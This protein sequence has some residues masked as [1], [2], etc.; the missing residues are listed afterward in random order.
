ML[1][2]KNIRKKYITGDLTQIA[3]DGISLTFRDNEFVAIL[4]PSGSGKTAL[5]NFEGGLDRYVSGDLVIK[6][7]STKK[8]TDRDWDTYRNHSI[9]FVFQ[10]YNLIGHQSILSNVALALT[11]SGISRSECRRRAKEALEKVGLGDQLHKRPNQ[12]SGGQMQRVAI[13]RA[14]VNNPDILLADEPTGA[15]DTETG[16]QVME[17]LK[18]VAKDRLVVMVTHNPELA[19]TYATRTVRVRDGKLLSDSNPYTEEIPATQGTAPSKKASMSFFTALGLSAN[20]LMTKKGRTIL[21]AFAGA[22][23]IIGIALILSL[24]S[25]VTAYIDDL[26]KGTMASY[27]ITISEETADL[28]SLIDAHNT[29][30]GTLLMKKDLESTVYSDSTNMQ[31]TSAITTLLIENNLTGFKQYLDDPESEIWEYVGENGIVYSYNVE[32]DVYTTTEGGSY[33]NTSRDLD[34]TMSSLNSSSASFLSV[35]GASTSGADNFSELT[36][37]NDDAVISNVILDSYDVVAGS[38]PTSYDEVVLVLDQSNAIDT[39]VLC[40]LGII[41]DSQYSEIQEKIADGEEYSELTF[42]FEDLLGLEFSL[43]TYSDYYTENEDG[44]FSYV[45]DDTFSINALLADSLTLTV[46]G[47]IRPNDDASTTVSTAVAYTSLLTDWI[48]AHTDESDV[49][50]AQEA[51]PD[52]NVLTGRSFEE[53]TDEE[54]VALITEYLFSLSTEEKANFMVLMA[55]YSDAIDSSMLANET[56]AAQMLDMWLSTSADED[57]LLTLYDQY[58]STGSYE[59][60]MD[61]FGKVSYDT[62]SSISI[63]CDSFEDKDGIAA[64]IEA[65]NSTVDDEYQIT[66]T[67]YVALLTST[68][69]TIINVISYVLI[70]FV[71]VSLVVSCIMIAIIMHISVLERTKEIGILRAIGASKSNISQVF[72]AETFI[73]GLI[74]GLIGVGVTELLIFP[75]NA[76][77][78][79]VSDNYDLNAVLYLHHAIILILISMAITVLG[80]LIP[81][82]KAAKKDPVIALRTE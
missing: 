38:W 4:G 82:K 68:I 11:I 62:P 44:T 29:S 46:V 73:I 5:L 77:I 50:K 21:T 28:S 75:I 57:T 64:A 10:S 53:P 49:V 45:G 55:Y 79:I 78:H 12:L 3:L 18:E 31:L 43:L 63:Y 32:F 58:F 70:A 30:I 51:D 54:K 1:Q 6:G 42:S 16:I 36:A 27:P 25:G 7:I 13:A 26:Q 40:Q 19:E 34:E 22:I 9:G 61:S 39:I 20:N 17:L 60:N 47:I 67:D 14:L 81:A 23:G 41:S 59:E 8:Y 33:L 48:I 52:T 2:I 24:S 15:L 71:A 72:N 74:S 37:G 35:M 66:Y 56:M 69:T 65:Y 80:G 76:I